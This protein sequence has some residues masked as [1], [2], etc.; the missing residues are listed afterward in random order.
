M[1]RTDFRFIY[2]INRTAPVSTKLHTPSKRHAKMLVSNLCSLTFIFGEGYV[3][4]RLICL[5]LTGSIVLGLAACHTPKETT[6][7][8][9]TVATESTTAP[10]ETESTTSASETPAVTESSKADNKLGLSINEVAYK[11][12]KELDVSIDD[13]HFASKEYASNNKE[14]G[15]L[16]CVYFDRFESGLK[17]K[18]DGYNA[19]IANVYVVE[20]DI[21]SEIY[22]NLS[23][24]SKV[25]FFADGRV[26][27][28][29]T[30]IVKQYVLCIDM[31]LGN[32]NQITSPER[33]TAAPFKVGKVQKAYDAFIALSPNEIATENMSISG[34]EQK[35]LAV[36]GDKYMTLFTTDKNHT[37]DNKKI[38]VLNYVA[39]TNIDSKL[40]KKING[41]D[42][43]R[44]YIYLIEFD[45][46]SA[47]YKNLL[48]GKTCSFFNKNLKDKYTVTAICDQYVLCIESSLGKDGYLYGETLQTKPAFTIKEVQNL[49]DKFQDII[50]PPEG[51]ARAALSDVTRDILKAMGRTTK[52]TSISYQEKAEVANNNKGIG[53]VNYVGLWYHNLNYEIYIIEFDINSKEYKDLAVGKRVGFF[54]GSS[55]SYY[56]VTAINKQYVLFLYEGGKFENNQPPF[57][58]KGAQKAYDAFM[59]IK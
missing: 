4:K 3:M 26:R 40:K 35:M 46:S 54:S 53:V 50:P 48:V 23:V 42:A 2:Y 41:Y 32:D 24:G 14:L 10:S 44:V 38:G 55:K 33:Y 5:F 20:Y 29:V 39:I 9:T 49:Y 13:A 59:A 56:Y 36:L 52:N 6:S 7:T 58:E 25:Q 15:V 47:E 8:E 27:S 19:Y 11:L 30:A 31:G 18:I 37:E 43:Y 21:E 12:M 1:P 16:D 17:E 51:K 28:L 45:T 22:K 34:I 57:K